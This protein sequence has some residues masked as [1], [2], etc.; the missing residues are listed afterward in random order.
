MTSTIP[1]HVIVEQYYRPNSGTAEQVA[2]ALNYYYRTR[3]DPYVRALSK[4][5][6]QRIWD[7]ELQQNLVLRQL[8]ERPAQ[9]FAPDNPHVQLAERLLGAAAA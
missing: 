4:H 8:G 9:G 1:R 7:E 3:V 5:D 2:Y 6:V